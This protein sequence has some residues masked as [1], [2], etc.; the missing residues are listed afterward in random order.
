MLFPP[1]YSAGWFSNQNWTGVF[2]LPFYSCH[3]SRIGRVVKAAGSSYIVKVKTATCTLFFKQF[4]FS[5]RARRMSEWYTTR[6]PL[7]T[8]KHVKLTTTT[9]HF[10]HFVVFRMLSNL[11]D[12]ATNIWNQ[13]LH[14]IIFLS[15]PFNMHSLVFQTMF[16]FIYLVHILFT[17]HEHIYVS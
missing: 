11:Q 7:C 1:I 2:S 9:D 4:S 3:I 12:L 15:T 8:N 6:Q 5:C 14:N 10:Q 13:S 17:Y 16:Q